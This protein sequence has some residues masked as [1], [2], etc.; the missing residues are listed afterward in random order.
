MKRKAKTVW[1]IYGEG[2]LWNGISSFVCSTRP[3]REAGI[4]FPSERAAKAMVRQ[5]KAQGT[6][7]TQWK[8]R[9]A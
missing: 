5:L 6:E 1:V 3:D 8:V 7:V 2:W 9:Q 4:T